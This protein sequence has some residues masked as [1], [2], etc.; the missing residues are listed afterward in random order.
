[1]EHCNTVVCFSKFDGFENPPQK[2]MGSAEPVEP[3][4]TTALINEPQQS[5]RTQAVSS[6]KKFMWARALILRK[7]H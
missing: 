4:L 2:L 5:T 3:P 1:M 7:T 6:S